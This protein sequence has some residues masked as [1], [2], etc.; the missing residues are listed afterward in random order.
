L[1]AITGK[2]PSHYF[3]LNNLVQVERAESITMKLLEM[4]ETELAVDRLLAIVKGGM[5]K[6]MLP[7][8]NF[9]VK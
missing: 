1:S 8:F 6:L 9:Q 7:K 4:S 3:F 5:L 2:F